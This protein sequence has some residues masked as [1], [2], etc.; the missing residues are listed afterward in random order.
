MCLYTHHRVSIHKEFIA[1]GLSE[2]W[3][4]RLMVTT[5]PRYEAFRIT[6]PGPMTVN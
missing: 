3:N 1:Q 2:T 6:L 4:N 5:D